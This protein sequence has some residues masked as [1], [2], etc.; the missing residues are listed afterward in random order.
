MAE[1][2]RVVYTSRGGTWRVEKLDGTYRCD[3]RLDVCTNSYTSQYLVLQDGSLF[4]KG[5]F[6][7]DVLSDQAVRDVLRD[8]V[9]AVVRKHYPNAEVIFE[10]RARPDLRTTCLSL[11][12]AIANTG[13]CFTAVL[14]AAAVELRRAQRRARPRGGHRTPHRQG[15]P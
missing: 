5:R 1:A 8:V 9:A 2:F 11:G 10:A 3:I 15:A 12:A 13:R 6:V 7:F 4:D 14:R